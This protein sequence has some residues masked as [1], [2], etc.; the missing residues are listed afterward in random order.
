MRVWTFM[1]AR[2]AKSRPHTG[3]EWGLDQHHSNDVSNEFTIK[4][5]HMN[6]YS[7]DGSRKEKKPEIYYKLLNVK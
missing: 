4:D 5:T 2:V 6:I 7:P 3:Q 1:L